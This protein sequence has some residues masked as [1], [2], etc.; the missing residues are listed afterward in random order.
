MRIPLITGACAC[1]TRRVHAERRERGH[2]VAVGM[3]PAGPDV[4]AAVDRHAPPGWS[5][6]PCRRRSPRA[7]RGRVRTGPV[8]RPGPVGGRGS[9]SPDRAVHEG[10][11]VLWTGEGR[12]AGSVRATAA[13]PPPPAAGSGLYRG[14]PPE[15][16]L[17]H[18]RPDRAARHRTSP[19]RRNARA[20]PPPLPA[21]PERGPPW[22]AL[23]RLA[24]HGTTTRPDR[25]LVGEGPP[26]D[27]PAGPAPGGF[28]RRAAVARRGEGRER[29]PRGRHTTGRGARAGPRAH[30]QDFPRPR[31]SVP[32]PAPGVRT[33]TAVACSACGAVRRGRRLRAKDTGRDIGTAAFLPRR[34]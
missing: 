12:D 2:A 18:A 17:G 10:V 7:R 23:R 16:S 1:L 11:T 6:P 24:T 33:E 3:T 21:P 27:H 15:G 30:A 31:R 26:R 22:R 20:A 34:R 29:A 8:A 25:T 9:S 19:R 28:L 13:L 14:E 4:V 5:W 32:R